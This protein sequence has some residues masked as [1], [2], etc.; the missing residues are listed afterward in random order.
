MNR[1]FQAMPDERH[2]PGL[3]LRSIVWKAL[4]P[5]Y[6]LHINWFLICLPTQLFFNLPEFLKMKAYKTESEDFYR[7]LLLVR[8]CYDLS[9]SRYD[10]ETKNHQECRAESFCTSLSYTKTLQE[11]WNWDEVME[12]PTPYNARRQ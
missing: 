1:N 11:N 7:F 4:Y 10:H 6:L 2:S 8:Q 12:L 9:S 5:R 3:Q